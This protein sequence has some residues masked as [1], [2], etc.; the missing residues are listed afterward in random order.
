MVKLLLE[1][2]TDLQSALKLAQTVVNLEPSSEHQHI[3]TLIQKKIDS[4][5]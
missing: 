3:L 5:K 2:E 1:T 4:L